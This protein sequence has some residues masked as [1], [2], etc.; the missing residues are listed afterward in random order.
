MSV[1][2]LSDA[3]VLGSTITELQHGDWNKCGIGTA[4]NA[5]G[6]QAHEFHRQLMTSYGNPFEHVTII[7]DR[8]QDAIKLWPWLQNYIPHREVS[9]LLHP[10]LGLT[11][12]HFVTY[13][14][15]LHVGCEL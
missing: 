11:A 3:I 14:V 12:N 15:R 13:G 2:K 5:L 9:C 1:P 6:R 8:R 4:L 7:H 10:P